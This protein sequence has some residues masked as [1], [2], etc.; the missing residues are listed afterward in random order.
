MSQLCLSK[1]PDSY[2]QVARGGLFKERAELVE[3]RYFSA[4]VDFLC[5]YILHREDSGT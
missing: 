4:G 5:F 1:V 3:T 2:G